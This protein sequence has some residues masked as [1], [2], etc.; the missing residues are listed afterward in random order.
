M[1]LCEA[2]D[3]FCTAKG[4]KDFKLVVRYSNKNKQRW[5]EAYIRNALTEQNVGPHDKVWVC[6]PPP[7]SET[8]DRAFAAILKDR[9]RDLHKSN[10]Y[11]F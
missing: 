8:F 1:Q 11:V 7:M 10:L 9:F 6:G 5:D 4:L 2:L 3:E